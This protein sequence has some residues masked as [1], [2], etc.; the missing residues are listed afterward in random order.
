METPQ[1]PDLQKNGW[2][3]LQAAHPFAH[4]VNPGD[5]VK[6][7]ITT[8][9]PLDFDTTE[10]IRSVSETPLW[11]EIT[12]INST[13]YS[14]ILKTAPAHQMPIKDGTTFTLNSPISFQ[15]QNILAVRKQSPR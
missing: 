9:Y 10:P 7:T 6:L 14:G 2:E 12:A 11:V 15:Q 8:L 13:G 4:P 5:L 3:L 1:Q